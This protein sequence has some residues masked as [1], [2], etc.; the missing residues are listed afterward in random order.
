VFTF[1]QKFA[2]FEQEAFANDSKSSF[3]FAG[4][5]KITKN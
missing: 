5:K 1:V 4:S 3:L 2:G